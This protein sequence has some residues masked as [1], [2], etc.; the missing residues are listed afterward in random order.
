[1]KAGAGS[2]EDAGPV[3]V[4]RA[5]EGD[6]AAFDEL[7]RRYVPKLY[8]MVFSM[9]GNHEDT[10][11]LL[12]DV[13]LRA[14]RSLAKFRGESAFYTWIYS[15]AVNMTLNFLKRRKRRMTETIDDPLRPLPREAAEALTDPSDPVREAGL[16]ELQ[17]RLNEA[18]QR[19]SDQHRTVVT[20]FD[21]QG[22][23]HAEISRI[24]GVSEGTVRSR[25]HYAHKQLQAWLSDCLE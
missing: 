24:L 12:Q 15:I 10:D 17:R 6:R 14:Y 2:G 9:I 1:M 20:M 19:L 11:D 4:G 5:R 7:V 13:F 8:G 3:L 22:F 21:I 16:N 23:P 18:L 25:L